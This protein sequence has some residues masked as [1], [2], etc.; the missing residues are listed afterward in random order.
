MQEEFERSG[1]HGYTKEEEPRAA[2]RAGCLQPGINT[3][4]FLATVMKSSTLYPPCRSSACVSFPLSL[5]L[6]RS[7]RVAALRRA[8]PTL[9]RRVPSASEFSRE[10]LRLRSV[11]PSGSN[12]NFPRVARRVGQADH[13]FPSF[14]FPVFRTTLRRFRW[15]LY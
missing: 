10:F 6:R 14:H 2:T 13:F 1:F 5:S 4:S 11:S 7:F 15:S 3:E 9:N 12:L 8:R